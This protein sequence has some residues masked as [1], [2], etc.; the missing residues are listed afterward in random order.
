[1][2]RTM[3]GWKVTKDETVI[4]PTQGESAKAPAQDAMEGW[5]QELERAL[6]REAHLRCV[7]AVERVGHADTRSNL[8][9]LAED[10]RRSESAIATERRHAQA[11]EEAAAEAIREAK[12]AEDEAAVARQE[13]A[14][15]RAE[16]AALAEQLRKIAAENPGP[17]FVPLDRA[18]LAEFCARIDAFLGARGSDAT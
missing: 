8:K 12:K 4:T 1:M 16:L 11:A 3:S 9:K 7:L 13:N 2:E 14:V 10:L 5:S 15:T 18:R 6:E 17:S